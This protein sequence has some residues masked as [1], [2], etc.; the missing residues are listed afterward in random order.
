MKLAADNLKD[1]PVVENTAV[2]VRMVT[3]APLTSN[4]LFSPWNKDSN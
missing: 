3:D 2:T 4:D 1:L